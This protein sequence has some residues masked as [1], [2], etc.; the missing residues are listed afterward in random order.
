MTDD[1]LDPG[2]RHDGWLAGGYFPSLDGLRCLSIVPVIWHHATP[3]PLEGVLGRGPLGVDLFFALS[4]FLITTLLVRE[5]AATG[6]VRIGAFYLRRALRIF[7]LYYGVLGAFVLHALLWRAPGPIRDH[8]LASLPFHA[9][10]TANWFV[11]GSVP[12]PIVFAFGW[13]L[14]VEEQFYA[15]WPW[16]MRA[17]SLALPWAGMFA[18]LLFDQLAERGFLPL[19][20]GG[21]VLRVVRSVATPIVLGALLA[22]AL[23]SRRAFAAVTPWLGARVAA[24]VAFGA[25]LAGA[26]CGA[27]LFWEHLAMV[28]LVGACALRKDH[29]LVPITDGGVVRHLG[30]VSYGMYLVHVPVLQAARALAPNLST[31]TRFGIG[32]LGSAALATV[33]HRIADAPFVRLRA[34][35]RAQSGAPQKSDMTRVTKSYGPSPG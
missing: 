10:F 12:H 23:G 28:L 14:A 7:P 4:G 29:W 6:T 15:V 33:L 8:F 9:T 34:R 30:A 5:R 13:S 17:R 20:D 27:P 2:G 3:R 19:A 35:L 25:V 21:L 11:D 22:L 18:L 1:R 31:L 32:V 24:P 16:L 26:V